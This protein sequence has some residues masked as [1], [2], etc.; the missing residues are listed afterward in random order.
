MNKKS[1]FGIIILLLF[2]TL[3]LSWYYFTYQ[4]L[5]P[6]NMTF[7]NE[8]LPLAENFQQRGVDEFDA[9]MQSWETT[10]IDIR[11]A[12]EQEAYGTISDDQEHIVFG[13]PD[14]AQQILEL[15][16]TQK[17]L[18][19]CWHG[20]RSWVAREFMKS[21][22]FTWVKDLEWGIDAWNKVK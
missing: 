21:E 12:Y 9:E 11:L 4:Y 1:Q 18:I 6:T 10:I 15:D 22:W 8:M 5:K 20:Q 3:F 2:A 19:Y 7:K 14:F 13:T 17:Y 16:K